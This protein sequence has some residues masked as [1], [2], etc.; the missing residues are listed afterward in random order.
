MQVVGLAPN[1]MHLNLQSDPAYDRTQILGLLAGLQSI[2]AVSGIPK[3][4]NAT[5]GFT[6]GGAIQ[7]LA[8]GQINGMFTRDIFEPL[9]AS[10]GSALGLQNLQISD[11]F[12]SGFGVSAAKAFGKHLTAV[13]NENL[14]EPKQQSISLEAHRGNATAFDLMVYNVQDPPLTGFLTQNNNPFGFNAY[15]NNSTLMAVS[16]TNG[17]SFTYEHKFH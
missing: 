3:S 11:D 12:T 6:A 17:V 2:G 7:N 1:E 5:G 9:D 10:L 15:G 8:L 13:F 16:G 14:G 4:P